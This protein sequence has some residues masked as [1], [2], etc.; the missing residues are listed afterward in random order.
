MATISVNVPVI[1]PTAVAPTL[2]EVFP[3]NN[4]KSAASADASVTVV[5]MASVAAVVRVSNS[6]SVSVLTTSAVITPS[7]SPLRIFTWSTVTV[8]LLTV[9]L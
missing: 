9:E 1:V 8:P 6:A 3:P 7:V 4:V 5:V 2:T